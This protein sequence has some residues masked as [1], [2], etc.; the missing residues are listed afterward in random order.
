MERI[1]PAPRRTARNSR[2]GGGDCVPV[3]AVTAATT[4]TQQDN[5]CTVT[6]DSTAAPVAVTLPSAS[7]M[8]TG[9]RCNVKKIAGGGNDVTLTRTGADT[10]NSVAG[11]FSF[12]AAPAVSGVILEAHANGAWTALAGQAA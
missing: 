5:G 8:P 11:N 10:I 9:F 6:V 4:I 12:A 3:R 2:G 1:V 7:S